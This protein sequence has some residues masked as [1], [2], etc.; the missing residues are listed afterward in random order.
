M[1][2]SEKAGIIDANLILSASVTKTAD[3]TT[4]TPIKLP[5]SLNGQLKALVNVTAITF[6]DGDETYHF[7]VEKS[8]SSG[9]TFEEVGSRYFSSGVVDDVGIYSIPF[10]ADADKPYVKITLDV[11]G[12]TPSVTFESYVTRGF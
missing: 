2:L 3:F 10:I 5:A 4:A 1:N 12:T 11:A 8:A 6:D 7:A 9:G